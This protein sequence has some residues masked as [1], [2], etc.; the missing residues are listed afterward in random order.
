M[1]K[2]FNVTGL[3][4]PDQHYM[5]DVSKKLERTLDMIEFG[6]YFIINRPRQYGKTTILFKLT[7]VL[8]K[9][10]DYV[11]FNISFQDVG[12]S[13]FENE[14]AVAYQLT[15]SSFTKHLISGRGPLVAELVH[16]NEILFHKTKRKKSTSIKNG[17]Y[18]FIRP[19]SSF[20]FSAKENEKID[21][22]L[23]EIK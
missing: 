7:D 9:T 4:F 16:G 8:L 6:E 23:F 2:D 17:G 21:L 12:D 5:A 10:G 1:E 15:D 11:V 22:V 18:F 13:L 19:G 20:Y 3:C 14:K